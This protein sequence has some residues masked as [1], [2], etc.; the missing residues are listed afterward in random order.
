MFCNKGNGFIG[1]ALLFCGIGMLLATLLAW[2]WFMTLLAV[3][4]IVIGTFLA[5]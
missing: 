2:G 1:V 4:F 3:A 5:S